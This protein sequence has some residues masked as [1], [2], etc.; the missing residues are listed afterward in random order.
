MR[1][2]FSGSCF[3][4]Q[5]IFGAVNPA[6]AMFAVSAESFS[7]PMTVLSQSV[8]SAVRPSFQRMAGRITA[9]LASSATRP[10]ICPP[11]PMPFTCDASKP[12]S[13]SLMP[14]IT[15]F[16]QSSGACSDQ[17]GFGKDSGYSLVALLQIL[18]SVS[19]SSS[20][21]AEVPRSIPIVYKFTHPFLYIIVFCF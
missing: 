9:S 8:S 17:P 4:I 20:F 7:F 6:K 10:C 18:P 13:S 2:N 16:H 19:T 5:R 21:T 3:F 15:A 14:S 1:A 12:S 11:Q